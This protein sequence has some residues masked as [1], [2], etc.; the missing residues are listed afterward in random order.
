[1]TVPMRAIKLG[2]QGFGIELNPGYF[3]DGVAYVEAAVREMASPSLFDFIDAPAAVTPLDCALLG[4]QLA[5]S[6]ALVEPG[7][8]V[9][10]ECR[11]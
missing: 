11:R 9:W 4:M 6:A 3:A 5:A 2:R 1:M 10:V 7:L 8:V